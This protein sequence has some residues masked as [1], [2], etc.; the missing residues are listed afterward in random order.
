MSILE[1]I[2]DA[3]RVHILGAAVPLKS[4]ASGASPNP[5]LG[6]P[7]TPNAPGTNDTDP[8][9]SPKMSAVHRRMAKAWRESAGFWRGIK[10]AAVADQ[11]F[12]SATFAARNAEERLAWADQDELEALRWEQL[13][14]RDV[15]SA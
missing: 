3:R 8:D 15:A 2:P 1:E 6:A 7:T 9:G 5:A 13:E 10:T 14:Q 12:R 4:P 11:D